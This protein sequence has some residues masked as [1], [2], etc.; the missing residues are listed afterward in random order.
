MFCDADC[1]CWSCCCRSALLCHLASCHSGQPV[2]K[3][4]QQQQNRTPWTCYAWASGTCSTVPQAASQSSDRATPTKPQ[5]PNLRLDVEGAKQEEEGD[6]HHLCP[7]HCP[8]LAAAGRRVIAASSG[9]G[10]V[11]SLCCA[12]GGAHTR[13]HENALYERRHRRQAKARDGVVHPEQAGTCTV[14]VTVARYNEPTH[15]LTTQR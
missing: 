14:L 6:V 12:F 4:Q 7:E 1:H 3:Q 5:L 11:V 9:S 10:G 8:G 15:T 13:A 2:V